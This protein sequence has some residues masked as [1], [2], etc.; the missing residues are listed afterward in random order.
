MNRAAL[1]RRFAPYAGMAV[2]TFAWLLNTQLGQILPYLQC[3]TR[4]PL[5]A[6][7]SLT[8]ALLSLGAAGFSWRGGAAPIAKRSGARFTTELSGLVGAL[9]AFAVILQGAS[10]LV[11][12]GCER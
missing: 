3:E 12:T 1:Q 5:L 4:L 9:F 7:V 6:G 2:G 11:L 10:S 8:L